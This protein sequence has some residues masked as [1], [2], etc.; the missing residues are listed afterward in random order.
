MALETIRKWIKKVIGSAEH[1][2]DVRVIDQ[3]IKECQEALQKCNP[4][5]SK[6]LALEAKINELKALRSN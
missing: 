3:Q 2:M 5:S 1:P 4:G 6:H